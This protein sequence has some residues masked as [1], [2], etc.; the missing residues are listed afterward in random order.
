MRKETIKLVKKREKLFIVY[1]RTNRLM[2]VDRY[3][4]VRNQVNC[5]TTAKLLSFKERNK[6]FYGYVRSKQKAC[7]HVAQL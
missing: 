4:L 1:R 6:A 2:D 3:Q 5:E 7:S